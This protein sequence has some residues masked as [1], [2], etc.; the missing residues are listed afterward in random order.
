[1]K[2]GF[3][4]LK[5]TTYIDARP[6]TSQI[7]R[8]KIVMK[9]LYDEGP[10]KFDDLA[11][12]LGWGKESLKKLLGEMRHEGLVDWFRRESGTY[13]ILAEDMEGS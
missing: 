1:M 10:S 7:E 12:A 4:G 5:G 13:W 6:K 8:P 9:Y 11:V 2:E 3:M